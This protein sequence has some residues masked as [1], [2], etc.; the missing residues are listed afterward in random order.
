MRLINYTKA[1]KPFWN[2]FSLAPVM[3][4]DG[5][6]RFFVGVQV[7]VTAK[8]MTPPTAKDDAL[9]KAKSKGAAALVASSLGMVK[10]CLHTTCHQTVPPQTP[11][12]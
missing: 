10:V 1:G 6:V 12:L 11:D 2:M 9:F 4:G 8:E 7:D 3:G 5:K